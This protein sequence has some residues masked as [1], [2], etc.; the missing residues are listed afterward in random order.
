[1]EIRLPN[2][3]IGG[4]ILTLLIACYDIQTMFPLTHP[5]NIIY[6]LLIRSQ[7]PP[8]HRNDRQNRRMALHH[9]PR[10]REA[11]HRHHG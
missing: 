5:Y 9:A 11:H 2:I 4:H 7:P 3:E 8:A 6:M 10:E 1:M